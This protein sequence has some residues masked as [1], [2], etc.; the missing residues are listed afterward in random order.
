MKMRDGLIA[1]DCGDSYLR[2]E[3]PADYWADRR[4]DCPARPDWQ[5][6]ENRKEAG[7]ADSA[8]A[9]P[10]APDSV[11]SREHLRHS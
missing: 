5:T 3:I 8:M 6:I 4:P 9:S 2:L 11:H 10:G 1:D 7:I